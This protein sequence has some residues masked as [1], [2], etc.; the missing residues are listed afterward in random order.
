MPRAAIKRAAVPGD[1]Q[2][3]QIES[4]TLNGFRLVRAPGPADPTS[5]EHVF[6]VTHFPHG[7][8]STM[9]VLIDPE[10]VARVTRLTHRELRP[11]GAF[12]REQAHRLLSSFLWSE[13]TPP[14]NGRLTL[15]DVSR[16]DI[17]VAAAWTSD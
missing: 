15:R 17:D 9:T 3:P 8:E 16:D 4:L 10:A 6:R 5:A 11:G 2:R 14:E 7:V 1:R 13:G 12:W